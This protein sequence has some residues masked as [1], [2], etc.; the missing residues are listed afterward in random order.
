MYMRDTRGVLDL[1]S[2]VRRI[3]SDTPPMDWDVTPYEQDMLMTG[4]LRVRSWRSETSNSDS[5]HGYL[6]FDSRRALVCRR[7]G[8]LD[9]GF[10]D[11]MTII[12]FVPHVTSQSRLEVNGPRRVLRRGE[13]FI[14][15]EISSWSK[16]DRNSNRLNS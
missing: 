9:R 10:I 14:K 1:G 6:I 8:V 13:F 16:R 3:W 5:V 15:W 12:V 7:S 11:L 2:S 4:V